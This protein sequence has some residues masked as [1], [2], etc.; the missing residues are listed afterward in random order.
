MRFAVLLTG[1]MALLCSAWR[2]AAQ[3]PAGN[4]RFMNIAG[5]RYVYAQD[6]AKYYGL[7]YA[8]GRENCTLSNK[9]TRITV[10]YD[11]NS[12][13]INGRKVFL[14]YPALERGGRVFISELDFLKLIDPIMRN[15][16]LTGH[17]MGLVMLDPGHGGTDEGGRGR[18]YREKDLVLRMAHKVK[19]YLELKGYK[20]RMTRGGDNFVSLEQRV[21]MAKQQG[22]D[23]FVSIHTNIAANRDVAGMETFVLPPT[24]VASTHGS[25]N[26]NWEPGNKFDANNTRLGYEI[27]RAMIEQV[28]AEDRG[29]KRARFHVLRN[30]S[31]PA[32]LIEAGFL[33]NRTEEKMLGQNAYQNKIASA[34]AEGIMR[35]HRAMTR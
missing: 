24:G 5:K 19:Y 17:K 3:S 7:E 1:I 27:H 34:I 18:S 23:I 6:V 13:Y 11:K 21:E 32:V 30:I 14:F 22:A 4:V 20:V 29:L 2:G 35:Y 12:A 25:R 33:S 26:N 8:P 15:Q 16:A 31:C 9:W 28:Q 10:D